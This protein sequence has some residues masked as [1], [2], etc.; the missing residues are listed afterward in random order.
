MAGGK[1]FQALQLLRTAIT[2]FC[3]LDWPG[4]LEPSDRAGQP[5]SKHSLQE[6]ALRDSDISKLGKGT[7]LTLRW[8][9]MNLILEF[10]ELLS[11]Q[12]TWIQKKYKKIK[13]L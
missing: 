9:Q 3:P 10:S 5:A 8:R 7:P 1:L 4:T 12:P 2:S 6:K 13:H 11:L